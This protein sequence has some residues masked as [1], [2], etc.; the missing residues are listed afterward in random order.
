[1]TV[2]EIV[3]G[4]AAGGRLA[5]EAALTL[6]REAPTTL[7]GRM[8]DDV[9]RTKHP[10]GLVTYIID[11]NV[12]YTNVC[13]ARCKFCAFYRPVGSSEGYTLGFDEIYAEDRRDDSTRR[14][15]VAVAR[16]TQSGRPPSVVRGFVPRREIPLP[17]FQTARALAAGNHPH[18]S[19]VAAA[20]S[21]RHRSVDRR[22]SRQRAG[23]RRRNSGRPRAPHPQLLQQGDRRRMA[24]RDARRPSGRPA[25]D[26]DDDVRHGRNRRRAARA[27]V[28]PARGAGRDRRLHRVHRVELSTAAHRTGRRRGDRRRLPAHARDRAP[29]AGQFRQPP[30]VVGHPG[31]QSGAA[32]PRVRRQRHGQRDDR[33]ERRPRG[34]RRIL[35]G[36]IRS[37]AQ[38]SRAPA[39]CPSAATC[40][41]TCWAIRSSRRA[42]CRACMRWPW[43]APT[44]RPARRTTCAGTP[45]AA[46]QDGAPGAA[47]DRSR[48][49]GAADRS[50]AHRRRLDRVARRSDRRARIGTAAGRRRRSRRCRHPAGSRQRTHT[51]GIELDGRPGAARAVDGP[52]DPDTAARASRRSGRRRL[53]RRSTR[54]PAPP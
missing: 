23:W 39:S 24:R 13:V 22:R 2:Q 36:R 45:R 20:G 42:R 50:C 10:E 46:R 8:A 9:R 11:R 15:S 6:Y 14:R 18:F 37:R 5:P 31:R 28:P 1:M 52:V 41:T 7:L 3:S 12:N 32:Q 53:R 44:D 35:H 48:A 49:V 17:G 47:N 29:G 43:R 19:H 34:R 21:G 25:H 51:S 26:R 16:R 30:V 27:S 38:H 4:L 40:T 33:R 54:W